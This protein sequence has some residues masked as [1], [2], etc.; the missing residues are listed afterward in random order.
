MTRVLL[1]E[2]F[3]GLAGDMLLGALLD[4]GAP[5]FDL[6][7]LERL[8]EALVPGE[9]SLALERVRRRGLAASHFV[10]RTPESEHAPHRHLS[11][12]LAILERAP[13][14]PETA[15]GAASVLERLA[16]A[17]AR[18]HG[19]DREAVHFHEVGAVDTLID[20]AGALL[21]LEC[22]GI[23][24]VFATRP[25]VG[26]GTI[27]VAHGT[28]PVPAPAT[29]ELLR[30]WEVT[31][32][33]GGERLTPTAAALLATL[34]EAEPEN[35]AF[36]AEATGYGSGTRDPEEGPPN[37]A[38]VS[39]GEAGSLASESEQGSQRVC[40]LAFNLDDVSG[41]EGAHLAEELRDA[42]A[43]DVW[44]TPVLMKKGRPGQV[45]G[46]L[47]R[48]EDRHRLEALSFARSPTLGV[49]WSWRERTELGRTEM[50]VHLEGEPV[51]IKRRHLAEESGE[52]D[53]F[54]FSPEYDDL[55]RVARRTGLALRDL[56]RRAEAAARA[57]LERE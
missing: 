21:G 38:R 57:Q 8:A 47:C 30:G 42:G 23:E 51:R 6:A 1:I 5:E 15:S 17:E 28:M 31:R 39:I 9:A 54:E 53:P 29:E 27:E 20:I 34:V 7:R 45:V 52:P 40:E 12:L 33:P 55:A 32:G 46:L 4:L 14:S 24:R 18:V 26:S 13:L 56:E 19:I 10:L 3:G 37:L 11:D 41:E 2:P 49:R 50:T 43:L 35:F 48:P 36:R 22:L 16:D 44:L 25:Y